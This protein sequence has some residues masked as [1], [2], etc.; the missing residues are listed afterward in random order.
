MSAWIYASG[1]YG[2][3]H[4][5]MPVLKR[6][7]LTAVQKLGRLPSVRLNANDGKQKAYR[8]PL[9]RCVI[10]RNADYERGEEGSRA[11][12]GPKHDE[13]S[14]VSLDSPVRV[15]HKMP[16]YGYVQSHQYVGMVPTKNA[17][18]ITPESTEMR[19]GDTPTPVHTSA[20]SSVRCTRNVPYHSK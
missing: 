11:N 7:N 16:G 13:P 17:V 15:Q 14:T 20:P 10:D 18:D 1:L 9:R 3:G 5:H 6:S 12:G 19:P 4:S 8:R 2:V